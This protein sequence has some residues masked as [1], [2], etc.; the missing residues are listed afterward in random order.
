MITIYQLFEINDEGIL[1]A[2][3]N[4]FTGEDLIFSTKDEAK[5]EVKHSL[6][7]REYIIN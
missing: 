7:L 1:V 2:A 6:K 3:K 4:D 5:K